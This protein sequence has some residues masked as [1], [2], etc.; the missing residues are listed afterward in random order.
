MMPIFFRVTSE[1]ENATKLNTVDAKA[2][3]KKKTRPAGYMK[4]PYISMA[5]TAPV[6]VGRLRRV[7]SSKARSRESSQ[8]QSLKMLAI[9]STPERMA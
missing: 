6:A 9:G 8:L 3:A 1:Q 2:L 4:R 5:N 7:I